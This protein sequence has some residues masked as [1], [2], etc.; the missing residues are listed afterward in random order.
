MSIAVVGQ[1]PESIPGTCRRP[2]FVEKRPISVHF[3]MWKVLF[4]MRLRV[5]RSCPL[6]K[7]SASEPRGSGVR[8]RTVCIVL[9]P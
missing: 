5:F 4:L 3:A 2:L 1:R 8:V 7:L 6:E 9:R